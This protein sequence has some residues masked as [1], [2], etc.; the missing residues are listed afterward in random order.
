MGLD[1]YSEALSVINYRVINV[2]GVQSIYYRAPEDKLSNSEGL[3]KLEGR[4]DIFVC[5]LYTSSCYYIDR[6]HNPHSNK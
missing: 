4:G 3:L 1:L 6:M 5:L 2:K